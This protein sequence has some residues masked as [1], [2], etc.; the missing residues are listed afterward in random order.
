MSEPPQTRH[1]LDQPLSH[2]LDYLWQKEH[3]ATQS[4]TRT[5]RDI[6]AQYVHS[7]QVKVTAAAPAPAV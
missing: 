4:R 2:A 7:E 6:T 1:P 5:R 3:A